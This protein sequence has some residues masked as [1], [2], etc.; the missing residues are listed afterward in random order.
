[1]SRDEVIAALAPSV[2]AL[3]EQAL[4]AILAGDTVKAAELA[5]EAARRQALI[6]LRRLRSKNAPR[7]A[8]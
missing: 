4:H 3:A 2:I 8:K 6:N 7:K 5:E 1:M